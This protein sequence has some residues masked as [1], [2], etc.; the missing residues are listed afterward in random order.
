MP[1]AGSLQICAQR[2]M[3]P[4]TQ[5]RQVPPRISPCKPCEI[6]PFG[7]G[8]AH[9][10][11][12]LLQQ[13]AVRRAPSPS[14][15]A[16]RAVSQDGHPV[17]PGSRSPIPAR[18]GAL[19][20]ERRRSFR[21]KSQLHWAGCGP[22]TP[23]AQE[24]T[25]ARDGA[26]R[27]PANE[28]S[29]K[30]ATV[31]GN[32]ACFASL[33]GLWRMASTIHKQRRVCSSV[34]ARMPVGVQMATGSMAIAVRSRYNALQNASDGSGMKELTWVR[35]QT[36]SVDVNLCCKIVGTF[37]QP[38]RCSV[39]GRVK[40]LPPT[41]SPSSHS[42]HCLRPSRDSLSVGRARRCLG[43]SCCFWRALAHH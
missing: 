42:T 22:T 40:N 37:Q 7:E 39:L 35:V 21:Q 31:A 24:R 30:G 27:V 5:V 12:S 9:A 2:S 19:R 17:L 8:S 38:G 1:N 36:Q 6:L 14:P 34:A 10:K 4:I 15:V 25:K 28:I 29:L 32:D 43:H 41:A 26:E 33:F 23:A 11:T 3:A 16:N 18:R 13:P 20:P